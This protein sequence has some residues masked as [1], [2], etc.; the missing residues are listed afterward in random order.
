[1]APLPKEWSWYNL[2][3]VKKCPKV[4]ET[5]HEMPK[6]IRAQFKSPEPVQKNTFGTLKIPTTNHVFKLYI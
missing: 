3:A 5:G 4:A 2:G 6:Y 1:M